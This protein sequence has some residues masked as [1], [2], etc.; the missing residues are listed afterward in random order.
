MYMRA[1]EPKDTGRMEEHTKHTDAV[2]DLVGTIEARLGIT[3]IEEAGSFHHGDS[4]SS[5]YPVFVDQGTGIFGETR[6][7]IFAKHVMENGKL[8]YMHFEGDHG[9]IFTQEVKGQ[10]PHLFIAATM[11]FAEAVLHSDPHIRIA[12]DEMAAEAAAMLPEE[13]R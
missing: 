1:V 5:H 9:E 13:I 3:P 10:R 4:D 2:D 7:P 11:A 8:G 6:T 12:L